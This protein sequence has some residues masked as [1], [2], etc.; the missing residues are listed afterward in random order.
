MIVVSDG[1][2]DRT[3]EIAESVAGGRVRVFASASAAAREWR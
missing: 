1:S 2:S 3:A